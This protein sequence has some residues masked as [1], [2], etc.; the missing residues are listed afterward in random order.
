MSLQYKYVKGVY[1]FSEGPYPENITD[2]YK[3]YTPFTSAGKSFASMSASYHDKSG[4]VIYYDETLAYDQN[5]GGWQ[6][7]SYRY[8]DYGTEETEIGLLFYNWF[9]SYTAKEIP[10]GVYRFND[11]VDI[12]VDMEETGLSFTSGGSSYASIIVVNNG[13]YNFALTYSSEYDKYN[14]ICVL[15]TAVSA[16]WAKEEYKTIEFTS[17]GQYVSSVFYEWF[18][19]NTSKYSK[20]LDGTYV[21]NDEFASSSISVSEGS[22]KFVSNGV[23]FTGMH[24]AAA[25]LGLSYGSTQVST[26]FDV[27]PDENYKIVTFDNQYVSTEFYEW[28]ISNTEVYRKLISGSYTFND[29]LNG[30]YNMS[31]STV[32]FTSNNK[33]FTGMYFF[34]A[35]FGLNY[36]ST[37][38]TNMLD[39]WPNVNYKVVT[40]DN[41]YVSYDFYK[42]LSENAIP[43]VTQYVI[44]AVT[45]QEIANAIKSKTGK[46][47]ILLVRDFASEIN[48]I[49]TGSSEKLEQA[50]EEIF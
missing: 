23:E 31:N 8:V 43:E 30:T 28:I 27:W 10:K 41:Q 16:D 26:M 32:T 17:D 35:E 18:I 29:N 50:E 49:E 7:E 15:D 46:T 5:Y 3:S 12:P 48:S 11:V 36:G 19:G 2:N 25:E 40:F 38:V 13:P 20:I 21:F 39:V 6:N 34:A 4:F 37:Q 44:Q 42:W 24:F 1:R 45:L 33:R 47:D 22:V 9:I 14:D